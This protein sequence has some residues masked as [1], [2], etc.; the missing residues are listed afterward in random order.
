MENKIKCP[1]IDGEIEIIE[2]IVNIDCISGMIKIENMP[3]KFKVKKDYKN[4]CKN[5]RYHDF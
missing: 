1:L 4:I 5:C 3:D 2:C